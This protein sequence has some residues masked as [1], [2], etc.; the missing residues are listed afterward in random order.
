V[1]DYQS[2]TNTTGVASGYYR[3]FSV[4]FSAD[5]DYTYYGNPMAGHANGSDIHP[6][7]ISLVPIIFV[8]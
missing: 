1:D 6:Y 3:Y 2:H 8:S 7:N 5:Q 4:S